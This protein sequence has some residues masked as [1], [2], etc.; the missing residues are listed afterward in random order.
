[1][2]NTELKERFLKSLNGYA[3]GTIKNYRYILAVASQ[4]GEEIRN[5]DLYAFTFEECVDVLKSYNNKSL[6]MVMV[7]K[8]C[9]E[10]YI[11]YCIQE[12]Y[13]PSRINYFSGLQRKDMINFVDQNAIKSK[14]ITYK[15]LVELENQCVNAQDAVIFRLLFIGVRGEE[16]SELL[17]LLVNNIHPTYIQLPNRKI[18]IDDQTY[19]LIQDAI[20][21]KEYLV[22]NGEPSEKIKAPQKVINISPY[23]LRPSGSTKSGQLGYQTFRMRVNR[24]KNYFGNPY[25]NIR[26]VWFS[27]MIHKCKQIKQE[28]GFLEHQDYKVVMEIYGYSEGY[29]FKVKEEVDKYI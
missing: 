22:G 1:M 16:C 17:N 9:L 20:N 28:K 12:G 7:N 23:V 14:Y 4:K 11:N 18:E 29:M 21:Q 6:D 3:E 27:G 19:T 13:M 2:F 25:I 24:M 8:S 10:S 26:N 5:K 15:D